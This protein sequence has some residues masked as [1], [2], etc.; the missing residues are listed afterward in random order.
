MPGTYL[1]WA[2]AEEDQDAVE[3]VELVEEAEVAVDQEDVI[4]AE[5]EEEEVEEEGVLLT[6]KTQVSTIPQNSGQPL[7]MNNVT[8]QE[9]QEIM[10]QTDDERQRHLNKRKVLMNGARDS[11]QKKMHLIHKKLEELDLP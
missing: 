10:T 3:E 8:R 9:Q 11:V 2:E 4:V 7:V 6:H 5:E 1:L